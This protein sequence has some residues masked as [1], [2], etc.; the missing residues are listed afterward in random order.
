M[1]DTTPAMKFRHALKPNEFLWGYRR[2]Y[3]EK[4]KAVTSDISLNF[5]KGPTNH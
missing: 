3:L 5:F 4:N 1:Q 2:K